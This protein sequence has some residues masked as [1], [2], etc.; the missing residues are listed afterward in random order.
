MPGVLDEEI[1]A[2]VRIIGEEKSVA[3]EQLEAYIPRRNIPDFLGGDSPSALGSNADSLWTD[4]D[5]APA[6]VTNREGPFLEDLAVGQACH[7]AGTLDDVRSSPSRGTT[8][9]KARAVAPGEETVEEVKARIQRT[10]HGRVAATC[11][12]K[13]RSS[14]RHGE[15]REGSAASCTSRRK[16]EDVVC[17]EAVGRGKE[18]RAGK[19]EIGSGG[20]LTALREVFK[21]GL[22]G[23]L[24][25]GEALLRVVESIL[26]ISRAFF[27]R[28]G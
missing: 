11:D 28:A 14:R 27:F 23:I 7:R 12:R 26:R 17:W 5:A 20:I 10:R 22:G 15:Q 3:L 9:R 8:G 6:A 2:K 18:G 1:K 19:G 24:V 16:R 21:R 4:V 13:S 25:V